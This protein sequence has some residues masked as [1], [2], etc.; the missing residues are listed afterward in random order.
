MVLF[1]VFPNSIQVTLTKRQFRRIG[2]GLC[3]LGCAAVLSACGPDVTG[4]ADTTPASCAERF[5]YVV[6]TF[7]DVSFGPCN[8][9]CTLRE[10]VMAANACEGIQHIYL[11]DG[12]YTLTTR[13]SGA[14]RGDLDIN[15][16]VIIRGQ[17]QNGT[18]IQGN[19]GWPERIFHVE[20][21]GDLTISQV[22]IQNGY[23]MEVDDPAGSN[24]GGIYNEGQL[25][26]GSA[27][28]QNNRADGHGGGVF[29]GGGQTSLIGV[30][31][32]N[33]RVSNPAN[34]GCGGGVGHS[35]GILTIQDGIISNNSASYG[36][37]VCTTGGEADIF[38]TDI[39]D[40]G[41][42]NRGQR[43]GGIYADEGA[44]LHVE[45][46]QVRNNRA[47]GGGGIAIDS[48][49]AVITGSYIDGN[50]AITGTARPGGSLL[51][52]DGAGGGLLVENVG[53]S[54]ANQ[55]TLIA[56]VISGNNANRFGGGVYFSTQG[57]LPA[58][59]GNLAIVNNHADV[60]GGGIAQIN[61]TIDINNSTIGNN[62][63]D[64]SGGGIYYVS[65]LGQLL[66]EYITIVGNT[67]EGIFSAPVEGAS[68]NVVV[69]KN[70]IIAYQTPNCN[71]NLDTF[72]SQGGN[73]EDGDACQLHAATDRHFGGSERSTVVS[74]SLL[75]VSGTFVFEPGE[76]SMDFILPC[77]LPID[78]TSGPRPQ[79]T[80]G[81]CDAGAY[82]FPYDSASA[83]LTFAT[84]DPNATPT[85]EPATLIPLLFEPVT[86]RD[87]LCL[88]GPGSIYAV[89]SSV[90]QGQVVDL[91]GY[92]AE[93]GWF[94][95]DSPRFPGTACWVPEEDVTIENN[96]DIGTLAIVAIP[97][98][99]T[100]TPTPAPTL[101]PTPTVGALPT[102]PG[103][104]VIQ[105]RVCTGS[106]YSVTLNWQDNS[107]NETGFRVYR[108][109]VVV[110][111]LGPN[112]SSY[113]DFPPYGGPYT[114]HIQAFNVAGD[115]SY[116]PALVEPGCLA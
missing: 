68:G 91:L 96:F 5:E 55:F 87:T 75:E 60:S 23:A 112:V 24:G 53:R 7:E 71:D 12:T 2:L 101:T 83:P 26:V 35:R 18:I 81:R 95:I 97:P 93:G 107:N 63:T 72:I 9:H 48:A 76:N 64:G 102:A 111:T 49:S 16:E 47:V 70:T 77:V 114:Y 54:A 41:L 106:E 34:A 105:S 33:N 20:P 88:N 46:A 19:H 113:K 13:G 38:A 6:T 28:I 79:P 82:E 109:G 8:S 98:P 86:N 74:T 59:M 115:S 108:N 14:E 4:P 57:S 42:Q 80:G 116:S 99:P 45:G 100:L 15:S 89:V 31:L 73:V 103:K 104:P 25:S 84:E 43:G 62:L 27:T 37:G 36:A 92:G 94:I 67:H 39:F 22:T 90:G 32:T 3:L 52:G 69:V 78:Q 85:P 29:G 40:N 44:I 58:I 11:P 51:P 1:S 50:Q 30:T 56:S 110:A 17:S 66:L 61:G 65:T 10:A 21:S